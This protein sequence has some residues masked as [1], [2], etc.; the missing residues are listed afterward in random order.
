VIVEHAP[1]VPRSRRTAH[2]VAVGRPRALP[3]RRSLH[4]GRFA[5]QRRRRQVHTPAPGVVRS[6]GLPHSR[7]RLRTSTLVSSSSVVRPRRLA[8]HGTVVAADEDRWQ[9]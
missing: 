4:R 7:H 2:P 8:V 5:G 9:V 1:A 3:G 6:I